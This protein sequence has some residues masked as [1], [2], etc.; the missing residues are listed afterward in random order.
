MPVVKQ[1]DVDELEELR[2]RKKEL[3]RRDSVYS[4]ASGRTSVSVEITEDGRAIVTIDRDGHRVHRID[5]EAEPIQKS[6]LGD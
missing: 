6:G 3:A 1:S 2:K 5:M 4:S